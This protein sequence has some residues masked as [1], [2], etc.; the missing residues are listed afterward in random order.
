MTEEE[1]QIILHE[2][3]EMHTALENILQEYE[4]LDGSH[5]ILFHPAVRI[6]AQIKKR[7]DELETKSK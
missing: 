1:Q 2:W 4:N 7:T 5:S 3:C 6:M